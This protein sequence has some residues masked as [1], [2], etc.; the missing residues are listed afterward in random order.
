MRRA[1]LTEGSFAMVDVAQLV[2]RRFVAPVVVGSSP[3]VHPK[4]HNSYPNTDIYTITAATGLTNIAGVRLETDADVSLPGD[5]PGTSII[6]RQ[7]RVDGVPSRRRCRRGNTCTGTG[8]VLVR[9]P[10]LPP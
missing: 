5:G 1:G 10:R 4:N 7:L 9:S 2:E 3:I 6:A 8:D